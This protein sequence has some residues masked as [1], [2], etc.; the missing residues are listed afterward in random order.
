[1][2]RIILDEPLVSAAIPPFHDPFP[3]HLP[4]DELS[5]IA[6]D[7]R[8]IIAILGVLES[9]FTVSDAVQVVPYESVSI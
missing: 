8:L 6:F 7:I 2:L 5:L 9:A 1:M 4:I 3:F